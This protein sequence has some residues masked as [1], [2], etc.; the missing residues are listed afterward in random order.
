M[1]FVIQLPWTRISEQGRALPWF[2]EEEYGSKAARGAVCE[3]CGSA[4]RSD[5]SN[6][7]SQ[8]KNHS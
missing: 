6:L 1:L 5:P 2:G 8:N 4:E 7:G 3:L